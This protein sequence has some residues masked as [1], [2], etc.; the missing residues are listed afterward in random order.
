VQGDADVV[1]GWKSKVRSAVANVMPA[2]V[3]PE[4]HRRMAEPG[5]AGSFSERNQRMNGIEWLKQEHE[6]AKAEFGEVLA[7]PAERRERYGASS[8]RS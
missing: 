7:A 4:Q 6:K 3:L 2:P 8:P 5:S 1:S